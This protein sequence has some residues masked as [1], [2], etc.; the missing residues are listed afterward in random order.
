MPLLQRKLMISWA[1]FGGCCQQVERSDSSSLLSTGEDTPG[2]LCPVLDY[3]VQI[4]AH[5][6]NVCSTVI[7]VFLVP[8]E[9]CNTSTSSLNSFGLL[10]HAS[11]DVVSI[12]T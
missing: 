3:P 7:P 8:G 10:A 6:R 12:D 1:A 2:A 4:S 11:I 5:P 9:A